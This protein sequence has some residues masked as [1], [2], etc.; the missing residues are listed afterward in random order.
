M[1]KRTRREWML[2]FVEVPAAALGVIIAQSGVLLSGTPLTASS[3][4]DILGGWW[5]AWMS[6]WGY[7][8]IRPAKTEKEVEGRRKNWTGRVAIAGLFGFFWKLVFSFIV[9]KIKQGSLK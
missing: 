8:R 2:D 7:D 5:V 3:V 1:K 4:G 9:H 6:A